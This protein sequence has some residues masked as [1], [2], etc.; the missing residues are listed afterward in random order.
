MLRHCSADSPPLCDA[1]WRG[2][3]PPRSTVPTTPVRSVCRT[4]E[5]GRQNPR[6]GDAQLLCTHA[7]RRRDVRLV[8]AAT[9]VAIS[10]VRPSL[11]PRRH[12]DHCITIPDAV[13][14]AATGHRH[15]SHCASY[16]LPSTAPSSRLAGGGLTS[17]L[18]AATFEAVPVRAQDAPRRPARSRIR[19]DNRL[20]RGTVLHATTCRRNRVARL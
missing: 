15:T 1:V 9:S 12:P 17:A 13:V 19:Q 2:Q 10:P 4:L 8:G 3:Q 11:S 7:G 16:D 18:Y 5:K 20:L 6:R 14:H